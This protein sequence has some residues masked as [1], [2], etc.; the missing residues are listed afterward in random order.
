MLFNS[1]TFL[2]FSVL[3]VPPAVFGPAW[4]RKAILF[5]GGIIFYAFWRIDF[6]FLVLFTAFVDW[7]GGL[8]IYH[9]QSAKAK[10]VWLVLSLTMNLVVLGFFK[11][12]YFALGTTQSIVALFGGTFE[13]D[14][15]FKIILPLGIS[16]YTFHSLSYVF[17]MYRGIVPPIKYYTQF[18][19]Y[20][21]FWTQ[22]VAGPILRAHEIVPQLENYK[23]PTKGEAV[24]AIEE[25]LQGFFKKVVLADQIAPMV[26]AGYAMPV[27]TLG[28]LDV[29][30]LAFA[31]G[32]QIYFDFSGYSSI[33][34]GSARLMGFQ[35]PPN[36]NW[37]YLATSP[38]E[39]WRRWHI[40]LSTWIRDYLYL[41][42]QGA[43]FNKRSRVGLADAKSDQPETETRRTIALF[44]TWFIMGL[45][46]GANW[47]FAVWGIWHAAFVW[48]HRVT[49]PIRVRFPMMV[50]IVGGFVL[51][52]MIEM[53][54]W[55]FFRA[56]TLTDAFTMV[57]RALNPAYLGVRSLRETAYLHVF[58]YMAGFLIVAAAWRINKM[59]Q[60]P[61]PVRFATLACSHGVMFFFVFLLLRQ[62]KSFIY[63]QF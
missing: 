53:L 14:L 16:F 61:R 40:S 41:P 2:I 27:D 11:Y 60:L 1:L 32:F 5:F 57:Y 55:V 44:L 21:M 63:F 22:L 15:P 6:T 23:R 20:V 54:A 34:L 28:T 31:F 38:R 17:D 8:R 51:T 56:A 35:F 39:F 26:D 30:V 36:F 52:L 9:A 62:A 29:W 3:M 33:A 37:P 47:T 10:K 25:I 12:F 13:L 18:I 46:H 49:E 19:T 59:P 42:L 45:W 24:Y 50:R 58:S 7:Y 48:L 43:T 4:M